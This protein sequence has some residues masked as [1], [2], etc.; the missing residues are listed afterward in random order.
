MDRKFIIRIYPDAI[1]L[2]RAAA[3][4][5]VNRA[6][7]FATAKGRFNVLL[8]GGSTPKGMFALLAGEKELHDAVPWKDIHFFWGDERHVPPD[9]PDNNYKMAEEIL[10]SKVPVDREHV[11][12]VI[13][14]VSDA[15]LS[16]ANYEIELKQYIHV[17]DGGFPR[18][19]LV[20]LGMG[21]DGH[22]ASLFPGTKALDE[23]SKWVV[24]NWVGKLYTWRITL[25]AP[26]INHAAEV[27]FLV[28]GDDKAQPLKAVFEGPH[29]PAQL[30]A[31]LIHPVN[32]ELIWMVDAKAA[33]L[34]QTSV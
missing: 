25:T 6:N 32:G 27:V 4:H 15:Y 29:E 10:L 22:T 17:L 30:P 28:G 3:E 2:C 18:F 23:E 31:Q 11:H 8:S 19:D 1:A 33:S 5:F 12:R 24:A 26:V 20:F 34:L 21:P 16:A 7:E 14:E 9:H 13:S